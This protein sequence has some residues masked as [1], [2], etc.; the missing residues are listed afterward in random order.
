MNVESTLKLLQAS[1]LFSC[2]SENDLQDLLTSVTSTQYSLGDEILRQGDEATTVYMVKTGKVR[3]FTQEN[4]RKIN[5]DV[6]QPGESFGEIALLPSRRYTF[7][8]RSSGKTEVLHIS[9]S[10]IQTIIEH[11]PAYSNYIKQYLTLKLAGGLVTRLFDLRKKADRKEIEQTIR[12]VGVKR[13]NAG[14]VILFQDSVEDHRLYV[15]REGEVSLRRKEEKKNYLLQSLG[16]GEIFGEKSALYYTPQPYEI[17]AVTDVTVLV[18][19]E[20][21]IHFIIERNP[22]V[23]EIFDER[24]DFLDKDLE[25]QQKIASWKPQIPKFSQPERAGFR[26]K[27]LKRF[28]CVEQA[29]EMDCGAACLAMICKYYKIH[30]SLGKLREIAN[31]TTEGATMAS[32]ALAGE[33]VGFTTKGVRSTFDSLSSFELP[34]IAHWQGYHYVIIYGI[35]KKAVWVAD[36]AEG[37]KKFS[38]AEFEHG[39]AGNC[40][41]FTRDTEKTAKNFARPTPWKRFLSYLLPHKKILRDLF[42]GALIIQLFGLVTPIIIQNILDRVVVHQNMSLLNMMIIGLVVVT[43]FAHLTEYL[44]A[45]LSLFMT[46]KVD[47]DMMSKF[48][49]HVFS[50]PVA[51]FAKRKTGDIVARFQENETVRRFMTE[52][53]I[54]VLLNACMSII[55]VIVMFYYSAK[56]TCIVLILLL[57]LVILTLLATPKYKDYARQLFHAATDAEAF[58]LESLNGAESI[59]AMAVERVMRKKWE[60]KYTASLNI[61]YRSEIFTF[62]MGIISG[63]LRA[64]I[65]LTI[66]YLGAGLVIDLQLTIG[67][68]MAYNALVGSLLTPILG[69]VGIWDD[70]QESLVSLERLNDIFDLEKEQ[71]TEEL[72]SRIILPELEGN[73]SCKDVCFRYGGENTPLILNNINLTIE[74]GQTVAIVGHSGSGKTTLAKLLMGL[75]LPSSGSITVDGYDL[76]TLDFSYYRKHIG[77]VMQDNFLFAGSIAENIAVGE[78]DYDH[79]R[80]VEAAQLADAHGFISNLPLGYEQVVGERGT[81]MSGG[82]IQRICIA[83]ALFRTPSFLIFDEAV[84]ALDTESENQIQQNLSTLLDSRTAVIISHRLSTI[85]QADKIVVLYNG[86]ISE[87]GSHGELIARKGMYY[88]L[89]QKQISSTDSSI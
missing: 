6:L 22:G 51:F 10:V 70:F 2:L 16:T 68:F 84:S 67:Q 33:T 30:L 72:S 42:I 48:C 5:L 77:Y 66:L 41:L 27:V 29:E 37:F 14:Q 55:Y 57:P 20:K 89:V 19:P 3:L 75:Y 76:T 46:R 88:Y 28:E 40:L 23:R 83:R 7:S 53:S 58:L 13:F 12:S 39:W 80:V 9:S 82:Q 50:L 38:K 21:T 43:I 17:M 86:T 61:R 25:R 1:E 15:I 32:L 4:D 35:S 64:V 74:Q 26:A 52:S 79:R 65:S 11:T 59:K 87:Q 78:G 31:V 36:P 69:L 34:F 71:A 63:L 56:L 18:I 8:A 73:I 24:L 45:Y 44:R 54:S 49:L 62:T 47:F 60:T 81:G 85:Q